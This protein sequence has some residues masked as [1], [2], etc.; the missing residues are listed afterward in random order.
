MVQLIKMPI[1]KSDDMLEREIQ[2]LQTVSVYHPMCLHTYMHTQ[3][4]HM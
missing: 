3:D 4:T 1:S 2:F